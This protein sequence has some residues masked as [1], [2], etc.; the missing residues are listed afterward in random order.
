MRGTPFG[1]QAWHRGL[2]TI[3]S[4]FTLEE[5]ETRECMN[6]VSTERGAIRKRTGST[7]FSKANPA[8]EF[9][10]IAAVTVEAGKF[11]ILSNGEKIWSCDTSGNL[12]EIQEKNFTAGTRWSIVQ[13]PKARAKGSQGPVYLTNGVDKAQQWTG[14]LASTKTK[15]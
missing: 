14:A 10:S 7:E 2:N 12:V 4:P 1:F 13:A 8:V 3:D 11:L 6:V 15:E 9:T 5:G